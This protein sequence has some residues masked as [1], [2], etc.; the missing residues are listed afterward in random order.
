VA[1]GAKVRDGDVRVSIKRTGAFD[2]EFGN[3]PGF[4]KNPR[5]I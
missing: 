2:P 4:G 1:R 3:F 5:K